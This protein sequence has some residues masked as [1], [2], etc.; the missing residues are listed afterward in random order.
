LAGAAALAFGAVQTDYDRHAEFARYHTYSWIGVRAGDSLWQERVQNAVDGELETK[1]WQRVASGGELAV[2][3]FGKTTGR[4]TLQT[5]Y[6]GF[7][8]WGW[9]GW[10]GMG[11]DPE[12]IPERIGNLTVDLFDA[13]NRQLIW[14]GTASEALSGKTGNDIETLDHAV[15]DLF[16]HFPPREKD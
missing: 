13:S 14:R 5:F 2:S 1:G 15:S 16:R 9:R 7:P 8:G 4:D 12:A 3:A 6:D 10:A 11:T